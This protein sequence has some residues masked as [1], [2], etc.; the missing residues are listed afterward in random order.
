MITHEKP[1][2]VIGDLGAATTM[3]ELANGVAILSQDDWAWIDFWIESS[4]DIG[5]SDDLPGQDR[6]D[7]AR[8]WEG[9]LAPLARWVR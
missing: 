6:W 1:A 5:P 8:L 9:M 3:P 4:F 2:R 7:S